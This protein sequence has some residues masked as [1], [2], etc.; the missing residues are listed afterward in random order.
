MSLRWSTFDPP[1]VKFV[2]LVRTGASLSMHCLRT[3]VGMG[4][5]THDLLGES[6]MISLMK[7]TSTG[8]NS[9]RGSVSSSQNTLVVLLST[10]FDL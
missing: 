5:R 2:T 7:S 6:L 9:V 1:E 4:S 10:N 8:L 3:D